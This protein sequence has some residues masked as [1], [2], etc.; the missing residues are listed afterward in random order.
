MKGILEFLAMFSLGRVFDLVRS[1]IKNYLASIYV[2]V[3][4]GLRSVYLVLVFTIVALL[5]FFCGF[6]LLHI[7]LFLYLPW[8]LADKIFLV[9]IL[10]LFYLSLPIVVLSILQSRKRWMKASGAKKIL[11]DITDKS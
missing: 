2:D 8:S 9:T 3:V 7:A 10:G 4:D 11:D 6:L 5:L 1:L